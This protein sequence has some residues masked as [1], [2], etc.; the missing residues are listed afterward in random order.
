MFIITYLCICVK[1]KL[2]NNLIII[3]IVG[4]VSLTDLFSLI[5]KTL[6]LN[7]NDWGATLQISLCRF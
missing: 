5:S 2:F 4:K 3:I 7:A 6:A 1:L